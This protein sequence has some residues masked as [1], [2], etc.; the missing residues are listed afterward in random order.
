MD[1]AH[2][3]DDVEVGEDITSFVDD[4]AGSHAVHAPSVVDGRAKVLSGV[5]SLEELFRVAREE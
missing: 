5:T 4:D 1:A 2:S 3:V